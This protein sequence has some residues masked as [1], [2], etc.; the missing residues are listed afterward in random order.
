MKK[1]IIISCFIFVALVVC[2]LTVHGAFTRNKNING[3][4]KSGKIL[5]SEIELVTYNRDTKKYSLIDENTA[6]YQN[7]VLICYASK[8]QVYNEEGY[9]ELKDLGVN[10]SLETD[11]NVR[12][13]IKVQD[14]WMSYKVYPSG[15]KKND[16]IAKDITE[17]PFNFD[18][19]WK[20]DPE[21]GYAYYQ[22][23]LNAGSSTGISVIKYGDYEK[24]LS[25]AVGGYRETII[26]SISF[27]LDIVQANRAEAI[28]G[29][30]FE[31]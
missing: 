12:L 3:Q 10:V 19:N 25:T 27:Q 14:V 28:W 1:K 15:T 4:G 21:T 22:G 13:R 9:S 29:V 5:D 26:V 11:I 30:T 16:I 7:G 24:E 31:N 8:K 2:G 23:I 18:S 6:G 17:N 20:Y